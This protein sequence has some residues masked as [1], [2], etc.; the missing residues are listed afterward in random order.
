MLFYPCKT[1]GKTFSIR[2]NTYNMFVLP[3]Y[4]LAKKIKTKL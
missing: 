3:L 4:K 2:F 1:C